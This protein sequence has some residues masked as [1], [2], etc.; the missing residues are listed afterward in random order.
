LHTNLPHID[1]PEHYQFVT[2]RT[3]DSIDDYLK[4]MF[5]EDIDNRVKQYKIDQHLDKSTKGNY[6]NDTVIDEIKRYFISYDKR[7]FEIIAFCIMPNHIHI[8]FK[9]KE[10]L[11]EVLRVIKGGSAHIA[12][13]ILER[14]GKFWAGKYY[15]A[16]IRDEEHF[17]SVYNYIKENPQKAGLKDSDRRFFGIYE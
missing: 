11:S 7:L 5:F 10:P 2:F 13:N 16:V 1:A 8:L 3:K 9:Q 15:D 6:L 14:K 12:N 17:N 4:K